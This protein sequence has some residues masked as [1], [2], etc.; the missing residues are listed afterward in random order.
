VL[1][2]WLRTPMLLLRA[3][4]LALVMAEL[5]WGESRMLE[6]VGN[7]IRAIFLEFLLRLALAPNRAGFLRANWL[8]AIALVAPAFRLLRGFRALRLARAV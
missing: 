3:A 1:E 7:V 6:T 2:G 5:A 4:W 8:S